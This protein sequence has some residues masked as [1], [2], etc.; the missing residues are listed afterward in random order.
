MMINGPVDYF[1]SFF[2]EAVLKEHQDL[3]M[4]DIEGIPMKILIRPS[5][6][7]SLRESFDEAQNPKGSVI[8]ISSGESFWV[9]DD[10][11]SVTEKLN[12]KIA[13]EGVT[14]V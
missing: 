11:M 3:G 2:G 14:R 1:V 5:S 6:V 8:Y 13:N 10:V 7:V 4:D 12:I 9:E